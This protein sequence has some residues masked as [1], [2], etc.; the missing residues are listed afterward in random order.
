MFYSTGIRAAELIGLLD[1]DVDVVRNEL[2]VL[3]KRNKERTI[4]F[5]G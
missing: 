2:K 1:A 3:G 4:P 5:G